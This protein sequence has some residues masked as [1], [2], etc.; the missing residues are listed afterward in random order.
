MDVLRNCVPYF[1]EVS[2]DQSLNSG[3]P[4]PSAPGPRNHGSMM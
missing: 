2:V 1:S 3:P 4:G